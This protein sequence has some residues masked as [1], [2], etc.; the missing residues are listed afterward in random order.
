VDPLVLAA[1]AALALGLV[2]GASFGHARGRAGRGLLGS[3]LDGAGDSGRSDASSDD[4]DSLYALSARLSP[5]YQ[6]T[7]HPGDLLGDDTFRRAVTLLRRPE[8]SGA[9]LVGYFVGDNAIIACM[10]A[11]ALAERGEA[12]GLEGRI[13]EVLGTVAPWPLYFALGYL[14]AVVP[15]ERPIAASVLARAVPHLDYRLSRQFLS[16]FVSARAERGEV[17]AFGDE[18]ARIDAD[19]LG[20]LQGFLRDLDPDLGG[21]LLEDLHRWQRER[22]DLDLLRAVGSLWDDA[23]LERTGVIWHD[24][25]RSQVDAVA[26]ELTAERRR[27]VV[28]VGESGVGKTMLARAVA[29]RL[30]GAGWLVFEAGAADLVAGQIYHGQFEQRLQRLLAQLRGQ[31]ILWVIPDFHALAASGTHQYSTTSALDLLLPHVESGAIAVLGESLPGPFEHLA[32]AKPR[33]GT[34]LAAR[35]VDPLPAARTLELARRWWDEH[36]EAKD[37]D[38][39]V[40]GA[41]ELAQQYLG[42]RAAPG[43]LMRLL[44][45]TWQRLVG[46]ERSARAEIRSD[47]LIVTLAGI[48]GLPVR[49]LDERQGL[50]LDGLRR[51]FARR[52]VGQ[53]EA[54]DCLVE[55][56][57]MIK[58]ALT[59]PTRP[60]G[61]FLFAGPTGTGK[62]EIAKT[63]AEYLFGSPDR[64][65]RVD[66]SELQSPDDLERLVG[67]EGH[68]RG[69]ALVDRIREQPF[70]VVLLDEFEKAH[71]RSWDLFLQVF[72]DGRLT[73]R[74]GHVADFRYSIAILTSNLGAVVPTGERLGFAS[75]PDRFSS[76]DVHRAIDTAFRPEFVNRLDRVVVFRPLDRETMRGILRKELEDVLQ[77]RGL[78]ARPWAVE[79]DPA[80]IEFLL[81]A[82]FSPTLGARPLKRA[83]ERHLLAPLARTIVGREFPTGDQFLYVT[84]AEGALDVQF[85]DPDAPV[86]PASASDAAEAA[87]EVVPA[88]GRD[89]VAV[90][91]DPRGSAEELELLEGSFERLRS[92]VESDPWRERKETALAM[93]A[94]PDFWRSP[95]RFEILGQYEYQGRIEAAVRR[96]A[97]LL[98]RLR[99][100]ARD[101]LPT[102][103]LSSVAQTLRLLDVAR[104]DVER[105]RPQAAFV[106]VEGGRESGL[107]DPESDRFAQQIGDMYRGWA[108]KRHMRL[109][110]LEESAASAREPWRLLL[111]VSGFGAHSILAGEDGLHVLERPSEAARGFERSRAHVSVVPQQGDPGDGTREALLRAAE[112]ALAARPRGEPRIVRRYRTDPSPLVRDGVHG[113]RSGR[114]DRVFAG[115]F[116]LMGGDSGV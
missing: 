38:A 65:I 55:R 5:F 52:V 2:G 22:I 87:R 81:E 64:M 114:I 26:A 115:D 58:A 28:L 25:L 10:A 109:E 29:E 74:R 95:D 104:A 37:R 75:Q 53:P 23:D 113:W 61:V 8:I 71:P 103:L 94:L 62:T 31:R 44:E 51:H 112:P 96:T 11:R 36:A 91:R 84:V 86:E 56:V 83:I 92:A 18:L 73:D 107:P 93:T 3:R 67:S 30:R 54:V 17:P 70:S 42:D 102:Q 20:S 33:I 85:I 76:R 68:G 97:S 24:A 15:P 1:A 63:L 32:L 98:E 48:T 27:S 116:D 106:L 40:D 100:R 9:D 110:V 46:P 69:E 88:A 60:F 108:D 72:D 50:D 101:H 14:D 79:W 35:R 7:A 6:A 82:G 43:N 59:D 90:A 111:A 4:P 34:A 77:R 19:G 57:A 45:I 99:R 105:G 41:W 66:M 78:R 13:L 21:P 80:A 16:D 49:I 39:V 47:D 89:L 12:G